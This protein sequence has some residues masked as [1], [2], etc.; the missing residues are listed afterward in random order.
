MTDKRVVLTTV[1]SSDE[2]RQI[3]HAMIEGKLAACVTI[4]P[5][6][7]SIYR[8][9]EKVE[10]AEEY[11]LVIK[12]TKDVFPRLR[13]ALNEM[14]SYELPECI[15]LAVEDG[16]EAYFKWIDDSIA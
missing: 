1:S 16:S 6:I 12:T 14:H 11:L 13:D 7:T 15:S 5:K 4:I 3:A 8:W 10:E 9:K 2:A